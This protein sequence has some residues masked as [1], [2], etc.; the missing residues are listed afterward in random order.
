[1]TRTSQ[2]QYDRHL[3]VFSPEG[4]LYQVEY[5]IQAVKNCNLTAIAVKSEEAV[6]FAVQKKMPSQSLQQDQLLDL[7]SVTSLYNISDEIGCC[8][9]GMPPDCRATVFKARQMA[10]DFA[11]KNGYG[12][13]VH[14]LCQKVADFNQVHT[15]HAYM[16]LH[17]CTGILI[18]VDEE[19][20]PSIYRF[21]P[22]GWFAGYK[23]CAAGNKEQEATNNLE[24]LI[25][26]REDRTPPKTT[27]EVV[28]ATIASLQSVLQTDM[29]A[30]DIEV[31]LVTKANPKFRR[32]NEAEVEDHL[33]IISERD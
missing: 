14:H 6:A 25:K 29:R 3:T 24:K 17:A 4:K 23:A 31:G 2:S 28:Q 16:R 13:P 19:K 26:T 10:A 8:V 18:G 20:G 33:T 1:M 22:A 32:L 12:I 15:Q 21:D 11:H 9:V 5:A 27:E 7:S 30:A